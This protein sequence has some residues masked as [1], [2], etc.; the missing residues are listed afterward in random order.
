MKNRSLHCQET[1]RMSHVGHVLGVCTRQKQESN[2]MEPHKKEREHDAPNVMNTEGQTCQQQRS[3]C[4]DP[5]W[6]RGIGGWGESWS[7]SLSDECSQA[8][9]VQLA[10][11][12]GR[13]IQG[14]AGEKTTPGKV[15]K[16]CGFH[17]AP[18]LHANGSM[19]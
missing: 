8:G 11:P 6:K 12:L 4:E 13:V 9:A 7:D 15:E 17:Q 19:S 16:I 2:S 3:D 1:N 18:G 10:R 14:D 5:W